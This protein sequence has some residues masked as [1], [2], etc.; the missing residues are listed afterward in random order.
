MASDYAQVYEGVLK[1]SRH[2]DEDINRRAQRYDFRRPDRIAK[3][4]LRAIRL[5][6][7]NFARTLGSSLSGYLRAYAVV[8]LISVEQLSFLE[9]IQCLSTPTCLVKL[10]TKPSDGSAVLELA[11]SLVFSILEIL[12]GGNAGSP[13]RPSRELT[14]VEQAVLEGLFRIVLHDLQNAWQQVTPMEFV[15]Q[16]QETQP[17]LLQILSPAE[18]VIVISLGIRIGDISGIM[19]IGIPSISVK[20]LRHRFDQQWSVRRTA[21]T[22]QEQARVFR[23]ID[24]SQLNV[25][26]RVESAVPMRTLLELEEGAILALDHAVDRPVQ[27]AINGRPTFSGRLA[28]AAGK[29]AARI[30]E[31]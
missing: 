14:E 20:M 10:R 24:N 3:D 15:M 30:S 13:A 4:Q 23:L 31:G 7:E 8:N 12:L 28:A 17:Q 25:D 29:R 22:E 6:H 9:F 5:M 1:R 19:N 18:A 27:I 26:A 16:G 21:S 2:N 11:P